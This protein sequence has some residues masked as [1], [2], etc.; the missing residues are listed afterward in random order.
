MSDKLDNVNPQTFEV[1]AKRTLAGK[2]DKCVEGEGAGCV[3]T[4]L[5]TVI[6]HENSESLK[7]LNRGAYSCIQLY[8]IPPPIF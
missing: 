5:P 2:I 3:I 6:F 1:S 4:Y 7:I 8:V